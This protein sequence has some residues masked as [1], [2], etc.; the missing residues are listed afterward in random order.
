MNMCFSL[1]LKQELWQFY[2]IMAEGYPIS[3]PLGG[4]KF[5][6]LNKNSHRLEQAKQTSFKKS[7][8]HYKIYANVQIKKTH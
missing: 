7:S 4:E 3:K 8:R 6:K 1:N 2:K 5:E